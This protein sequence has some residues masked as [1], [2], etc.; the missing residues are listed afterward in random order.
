LLHRRD[1]GDG[2]EFEHGLGILQ[3]Q[4]WRAAAAAAHAAGRIA[5][6]EHDK[7]VGAHGVDRILDA[8]LRAVAN[9]QHQNHRPD[10]DH[11]AEHGQKSAQPVAVHGAP[12]FA[13]HGAHHV[14]ISR[15]WASAASETGPS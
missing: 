14:G 4:R 11:H 2:A 7:E 1:G 3:S 6:R 9:G 5:A 13:Q 12:G 10:A 15:W 8:L